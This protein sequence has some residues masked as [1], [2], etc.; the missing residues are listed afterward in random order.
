MLLENFGKGWGIF[1]IQLEHLQK[2]IPTL[3]FKDIARY[4]GMLRITATAPTLEEQYV[5]DCVLYTIERQS[6]RKCEFCHK[7]GH[8][9]GPDEYLKETICVCSSCYALEVD[10]ILTQQ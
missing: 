6:A 2:V 8:R 3:E 9:Q 10:K 7:R 4:S 5:A 1:E